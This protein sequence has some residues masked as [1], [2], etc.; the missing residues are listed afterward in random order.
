MRK[1]ATIAGESSY[2]AADISPLVNW[3]K[4]FDVLNLDIRIE[5]LVEGAVATKQ[6]RHVDHKDVRIAFISHSSIDKK[7]VRQLASDLVAAGVQVWLDEQQIKVGESIPEK[8]A[9]GLAESDVFLV[10]ISE[11]SIHS[12]WVQKELNGA[13]VREIERREVTVLPVKLDITKMPESLKDKKYADFSS[14]Y[15]TGLTELLSAL[16]R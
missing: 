2:S 5:S 7:F 9:Q 3:A 12:P 10:V 14:S 8:V 16:G 4:S 6:Q 15:A 1:A 11:N 13:L